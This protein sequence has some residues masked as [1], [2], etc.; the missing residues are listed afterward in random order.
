MGLSLLLFICLL[1]A[2]LLQVSRSHNQL[3][4]I[5]LQILNLQVRGECECANH[6]ENE[7]DISSASISDSFPPVQDDYSYSVATEDE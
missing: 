6:A 4:T 2:P 5:T 1:S 3:V 7:H